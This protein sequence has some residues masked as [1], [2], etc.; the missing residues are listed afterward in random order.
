MSGISKDSIIPNVARQRSVVY[1]LLM[2]WLR[3]AAGFLRDAMSSSSEP[4]ESAQ[5]T[6]PPTDVAEVTEL[7]NRHRAEIDRNFEAVVGMINAE[8]KRHLE[9]MKIQRR[10]NYGLTA[11]L[12]VMAIVGFVIYWRG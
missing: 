7:L 11:A 10:W 6:P 12:L 5:N 2:S 4:A 8:K 1:G 9:A 3:I